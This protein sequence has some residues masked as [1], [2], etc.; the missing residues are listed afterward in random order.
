[1]AT[2]FNEQAVTPAQ[3]TGTNYVQGYHELITMMAEYLKDT[4][5]GYSTSS[6]FIYPLPGTQRIYATPTR[7]WLP[8]VRLR[9]YKGG[10]P[11][12]WR[13]IIVKE[14]NKDTGEMVIEVVA[15]SD[16]ETA[17]TGT[18]FWYL[19]PNFMEGI[20]TSPVS[21][22]AGGTG[23]SS[24]DSARN[25]IIAPLNRKV[26]EWFTDFILPSTDFRLNGQLFDPLPVRTGASLDY[27]YSTSPGVFELVGEPTSAIEIGNSAIKGWTDFSGENTLFEARITFPVIPLSI[28]PL[29]EIGLASA[30]T[31]LLIV[32][33]PGV[34][35]NKFRYK[36]GTGGAFTTVDSASA[37]APSTFYT[38]RIQASGANILFLVNGSSLGSV[39][40]SA[41]SGLSG[42]NKF[43]PTIKA[44]TS[45]LGGNNTFAHVDYMYFRKEF[46][47]GR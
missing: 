4:A 36:Y 2:I 15:S 24:V 37:Y 31:Q 33:E 7:S 35:L 14:Y 3:L 1:M 26:K 42:I 44:S 21:V 8:G 30:Q 6:T 17:D 25:S 29:Y 23:A 38:F 40:A 43:T 13:T 41:Y 39:P 18:G 11:S 9:A 28:G 27:P 34:N 47:L 45:K 5:N 46:P 32:V 22:S 12:N 10:K 20:Q 16:F 19:T